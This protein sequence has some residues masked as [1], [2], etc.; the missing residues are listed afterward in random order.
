MLHQAESMTEGI[1]D[2]RANF[3]ARLRAT[4]TEQSEKIDAV[5]GDF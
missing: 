3:L 2:S 5:L 1:I 4:I